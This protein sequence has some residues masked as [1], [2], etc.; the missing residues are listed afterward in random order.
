MER[1]AKYKDSGI[2]WLGGIPEHWNILRLKIL[3]PFSLNGIW[4]DEPKNEEH[5]V[6][7]IRVADFDM[8]SLSVS[9]LKLTLRN[10]D[11]QKNKARLLEEN[12][13]LI[14]KS[15]GGEKTPVGRVIQNSLSQTAV[16][17]NFIGKLILNRYLAFSRY[18]TYLFF[19]LY[20]IGINT[21]SIKQTTGIQN[22]DLDSYLDELTGVPPLEEQKA[23]AAYLDR[24]TAEI[25]ELIAQKERL[26]ALYEEEK[27][28]IINEAVTKGINPDVKL[29]PTAIDWLGDIPEHWE[30]EPI[31]YSLEALVDCEHKTAP[32]VDESD[33][34]VVRTSNV[35]NGK[36]VFDDAKFTTE[37]GYKLWTRRGVPRIGD[38]L[39]TREAPAG[40]AC[41]VP[42]K[43]KICLGQRM[44]WLKLDKKR[45]LPE[46]VISLIYSKLAKTYIDFL[47]AGSTVAHFNM[48]DIN[49]IPIVS[50]PLEEQK[51][52]AE[53]I[54][55]ETTRID[56]KIAKTKRII[57][58]QKEYRTALISEAVTGK[59]K[60]PDLTELDQ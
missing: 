57:E 5:D 7:C 37:E 33:Y 20:S 22:L 16:S 45:I 48:S 25:D 53:Y 24:K 9:T 43:Q 17:S 28:A 34:F 44:V 27:T 18:L 23:I 35:K 6:V 54:E 30:V 31:K 12:D 50:M 36:L 56:T 13:L 32:F 3:V 55:K 38:V 1:Y 49:N 46:F 29:K 40:E 60:I 8:D 14:E 52:I 2:A 15:G 21:R 11:I 59:I 42:E 58:L 4:G 51:A 39:L 26:I 10:I 47:S 19:S 41:L